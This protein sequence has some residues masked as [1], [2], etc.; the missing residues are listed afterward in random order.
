LD[1]QQRSSSI[2]YALYEPDIPLSGKKTPFKF[3]LNLERASS[4][5][6]ENAIA[7][8]SSS[9]II[10]EFNSSD[11]YIRISALREVGSLFQS[12]IER[13]FSDQA[14]TLLEIINSFRNY[15]IQIAPLDRNTPLERVVETFERI[16]RTGMP[17]RTLDLLVARLYQFEIRL[18]DR[19]D[20]AEQYYSFLSDEPDFDRELILRLMCLLRGLDI[21]RKEILGL[22]PDN[23]ERDWD[24]ACDSLEEAYKRMTDRS[25]YGA[26]TFRRHVPFTTMIVPLAA[27]LYYLL[28]LK[29]NTPFNLSKVDQWYWVSVFDNRYNEAVNT[30]TPADY[31]KMRSWFADDSKVPDFIQNFDFRTVDLRV[32]AK[33]SSSYRGVLCLIVRSGAKDFKS[34]KYP[35]ETASRIEDDHIWP[36]SRGGPDLVSNR[37]LISSNESKSDKLPGEFFWALE[38]LNGRETMQEVMRSHLVDEAS[39]AALLAGQLEV[40]ITARE[41]ALRQEIRKLVPSAKL[42]EIAGSS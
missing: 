7:F 24:S 6:W 34:A 26:L 8:A 14:S 29:I 27:M 18:R 17:L 16:N 38:T 12:L 37:T 2:F 31:N 28:S 41:L 23:F 32:S 20:A 1:G 4:G 36:K 35:F 9:K 13:G 5:D 22:S 3:Y 19:I 42:R 25:Y 33:S 40:F 21:R 30:Q 11:K 10:K 15:K 39:Y